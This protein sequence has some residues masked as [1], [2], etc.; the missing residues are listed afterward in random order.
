MTH[1][2]TSVFLAPA[3]GLNPFNAGIE[4]VTRPV[5]IVRDEQSNNHF[6][7][8]ICEF[9][10]IRAEHAN[11]GDPLGPLLRSSQPMAVIADLDGPEQDGF[12]VM[13]TVAEHDPS[14]PVL[15]LTHDEPA[16]LGAVDAIQEMWGL[17]RVMTMTG[18][19]EI[20]RM[21]DFLCHAA[22]DA[23][24]PRMMRL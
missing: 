15:L 8:V 2:A 1:I 10:G 5:L 17:E 23:G 20:G 7:D 3:Q 24:L 21:V 18:P 14:L 12:H 19:R 11:N 13:M 22:R 9:F 16:L 4:P 6:L